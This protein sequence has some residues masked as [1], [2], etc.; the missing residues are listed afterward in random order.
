MCR[1]ISFNT[2]KSMLENRTSMPRDAKAVEDELNA[3]IREWWNQYD[4][5]EGSSSNVTVE[6]GASED[7]DLWDAV[8]VIDSK[9]VLETTII[10]E[11][12][13]GVELQ[14]NL[15]KPGGYQ[16]IDELIADL[17]PKMIEFAQQQDQVK[18]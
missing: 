10:F 8:P 17:V 6:K 4:K 13:L 3:K 16:S 18:D 2:S 14:F 11:Q 9:L 15:I 7:Q 5:G 1:S 12:M